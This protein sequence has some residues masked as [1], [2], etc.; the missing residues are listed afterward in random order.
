MVSRLAGRT[1]VA[2]VARKAYRQTCWGYIEMQISRDSLA[3]T[4]GGTANGQANRIGGRQA[5]VLTDRKA[6][7]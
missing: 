3:S 4:A 5:G 6:G 7:A 2:Q 1:A